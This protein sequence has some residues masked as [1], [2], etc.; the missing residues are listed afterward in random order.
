M[1]NSMSIM[2]P[3]GHTSIE[4]DADDKD[5]IEAARVHFD[6]LKKKKYLAFKV[7]KHG[8]QGEQIDRFD[9]RLEHIIMSPPLVGG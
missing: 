3:T 2:D 6:A 4:W 7:D 5:E 9:P 1:K 8:D